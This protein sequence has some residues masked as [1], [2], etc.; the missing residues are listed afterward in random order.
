MER[1]WVVVDFVDDQ[2]VTEAGSFQLDDIGIC[3]SS[4]DSRNLVQ[5]NLETVG[6]DDEISEPISAIET[7]PNH[8][9]CDCDFF[10]YVTLFRYAQHNRLI[11]AF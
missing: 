2:I 5:I 10:R 8:R 7:L 1:R 9:L 4:M 11:Q 6:R 3:Q